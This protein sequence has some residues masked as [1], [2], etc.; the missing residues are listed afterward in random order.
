MF[1]LSYRTD[2]EL[3]FLA[4]CSHSDLAALAEILTT[5]K[6]FRRRTEQLSKEAEFNEHERDLT[7]VWYLIAA[8]LQRF[9]AD[10]V[11]SFVRGGQGVLYREILRDVCR[12][13]KLSF[14]ESARAI[15]ASRDACS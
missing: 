5:D 3:S 8:E 10:S 4:S 13:W 7:R 14:A 6:G 15:V 9:G 11:A 2:R 12:Q 1:S